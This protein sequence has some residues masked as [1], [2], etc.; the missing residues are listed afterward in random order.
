MG[1][2]AVL[3]GGGAP[4]LPSPAYSLMGGGGAIVIKGHT[5]ETDIC[6]KNSEITF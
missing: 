2:L 6:L 1:W 5:H 3:G 4:T